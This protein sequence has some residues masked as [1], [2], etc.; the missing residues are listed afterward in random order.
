MTLYV[1]DSLPSLRLSFAGSEFNEYRF[2]Q[3]R[4]EFRSNCGRW[5]LLADEDIQFHLVLHTAV[6]KWLEEHSADTSG[7]GAG[8]GSS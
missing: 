1:S 7:I 8:K 2:R 4:V 6:A 5:R 3:G